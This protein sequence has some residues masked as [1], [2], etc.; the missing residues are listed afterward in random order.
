MTLPFQSSILFPVFFF[1]LQG[2]CASFS[3]NPY[4]MGFTLKSF[5]PDLRAFSA[6]GHAWPCTPALSV[7]EYREKK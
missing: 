6:A 7:Q 1:P 5:P 4:L 3:V 2:Q